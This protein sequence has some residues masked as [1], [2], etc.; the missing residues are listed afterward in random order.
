MLKKSVVNLLLIG[1]GFFAVLS[2]FELVIF[3]YVFKAPDFPTKISFENNIIKY[4]PNQTGVRIS[5]AGKKTKYSINNNGWNSSHNAYSMNAVADRPILIIGDSYVEGLSVDVNGHFAELLGTALGAKQNV[6]RM[7]IGGAP[8]SQYLNMLRNEG[9]KYRPSLVIINIAHN[10]FAESYFKSNSI[11]DSCFMKLAIEDG[12]IKNE[13]QPAPYREGIIDLIRS[14]ATWRLFRYRMHFDF[15]AVKKLLKYQ[16]KHYEANIDV[17]DIKDKKGNLLITEYVF[18]KIK[19]LAQENSF[20]VLFIMDGERG[21]I[22]ENSPDINDYSKGALQL[23]KMAS[24][25]A[26]TNNMELIDMHAIFLADYEKNHRPF[27]TEEDFHWNEYGNQLVAKAILD[28][29]KSMRSN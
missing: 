23:N 25:V 21:R 16:D 14:S 8:L 29:I 13:I 28:K 1:I 2:V 19:S 15:S 4:K 26:K 7:G 9:L 17:N 11:Y 20:K 18:N 22:Y 27:N 5:G 10:D 6:Y 12:K 24:D 3:R